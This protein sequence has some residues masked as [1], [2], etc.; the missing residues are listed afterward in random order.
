MRCFID[1]NMLK[2]TH[3]TRAIPGFSLDQV[4]VGKYYD[5]DMRKRIHRFKFVHNHVDRVYFQ[6]IFVSIQ[7]EYPFDPDIIVYPP[8]GF[9]DRIIRVANH[10][11]I[12]AK[13]FLWKRKIPLLCPFSRKIF[14]SHQSK[15]S[16]K[17]RFSLESEYFWKDG[18]DLS[19]K[20]IAL[21]DDLITT[22]ATAHFLGQLL[23]DH[24]ATEVVGYFLASEKI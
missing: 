19:G 14:A 8:V 12:L 2:T 1:R 20:K 11:K 9:F 6:E 3:Y 10:A 22:G 24:G 4:I 18:N 16:R 17:E 5:D 23:K 13:Y 7:E 21:I 15:K